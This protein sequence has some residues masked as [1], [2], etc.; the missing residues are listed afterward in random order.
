MAK[1]KVA[2]LLVD[3]LA[4]AGVKQ[5]YGVSGDSLME[6][7]TRFA[8]TNE[9]SGSTCGMKRPRRLRREQKRT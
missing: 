9:F 4:E 7:P 2:E 3:V 5:I 8:R 6:L 1:K